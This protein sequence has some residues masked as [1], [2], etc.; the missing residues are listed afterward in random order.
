MLLRDD[1]GLLRIQTLNASQ[2]TRSDVVKHLIIIAASSPSNDI[3]IA[4]GEMSRYIAEVLYSPS[5]LSTSA[6]NMTG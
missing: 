1:A 3:N 6:L 5:L 4:W 2:S